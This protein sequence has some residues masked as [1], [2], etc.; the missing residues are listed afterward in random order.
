MRSYLLSF[1]R[2]GKVHTLPA[3][4]AVIQVEEVARYIDAMPQTVS[5]SQ[6]LDRQAIAG[7]TGLESNL[8]SANA[9]VDY[10]SEALDLFDADQLLT[11][12][13]LQAECQAELPSHPNLYSRPRKQ[14]AAQR[15]QA[16]REH[17]RKF[18]L[19][20]KASPAAPLLHQ[21]LQVQRYTC[22]PFFHR[23]GPRLF[24]HS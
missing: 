1:C 2:H 8:N 20:H 22:Q 4:G 24:K 11:P 19:R 6:L 3:G 14:D 21:H 23:Q 10:I 7:P 17:Q 16:N 13:P 9:D 5:L 15:Q 12:P 18:R